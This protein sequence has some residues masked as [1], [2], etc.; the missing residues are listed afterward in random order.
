VAAVAAP[1]VEPEA[2]APTPEAEAAAPSPVQDAPAVEDHSD[3]EAA[4]SP[5]AQERVAK[6]L[7]SEGFAFPWNSRRKPAAEPTAQRAEADEIS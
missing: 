6:T 7:K 4:L 2:A 1:A 3:T 5:Q